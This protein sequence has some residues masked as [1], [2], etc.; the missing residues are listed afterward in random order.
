MAGPGKH[1]QDRLDV[2]LRYELEAGQILGVEDVHM[3]VDDR[4]VEDPASLLTGGSGSG[5]GSRHPPKPKNPSVAA[6][7]LGEGAAVDHA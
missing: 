5:S 7:S 6:E 1:A 2:N 4:P 3:R